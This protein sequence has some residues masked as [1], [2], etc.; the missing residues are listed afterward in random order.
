MDT[1][2]FSDRRFG[3]S[4]SCK[5]QMRACCLFAASACQRQR[6]G[7]AVECRGSS[8]TSINASQT[9]ATTSFAGFADAGTTITATPR[10]SD[11]NHLQLDFAITLNSFTG[12]P[13]NGVPP[14]RQTEQVTS[15]ITIPDGYTVIVGGLNRH[16]TS[17]DYQGVPGLEK[18]PSSNGYSVIPPLPIH[19]TV[20]LCSC[21]RLF[22]ATTASRI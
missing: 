19:T 10:I 8:F 20:C 3:C 22:C 1:R 2:R 21:D 16:N 4:L 5:P 14:S 7:T 11:D 9:V 12:T 13:A 18:I 15:Q 6:H 17:S